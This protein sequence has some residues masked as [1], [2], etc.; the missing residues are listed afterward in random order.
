MIPHKRESSENHSGYEHGRPG[1]RL[2]DIKMI[3]DHNL[4]IQFR[5]YRVFCR[6]E[7]VRNPAAGCAGPVGR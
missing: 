6:R 4:G 2:Y 3:F 1:S 5:Q 7:G